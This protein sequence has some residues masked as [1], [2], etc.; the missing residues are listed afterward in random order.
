MDI[1]K[2]AVTGSAGSGKS[3]VCRGF[4][5]LGAAVLDCDV[6]ARQVVEPGS[7]GLT[8][9]T[10]V[11]GSTIIRKN[12]TL[13]RSSL[14][15][16]IINSRD[17]RKQL[18]DV[19]HP[20]ILEEMTAQMDSARQNGFKMVVVE[21]PLLFESGM[22]RFFDVTIA[23]AG[24]AGELVKRISKRDGVSM[25][26]AQKMLDLQ[27]PQQEKMQKADYVIKNIAGLAELFDLVA[28]LCKRI[29][30]EFLTT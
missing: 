23:V 21:V 24:S 8:K 12:G 18:E 10:A 19:L 28:N 4:G 20:L 25:G 7:P 13:D 17:K 22:D 16:L 2:I 3:H 1:L 27:M 29:E 15:T 30:K 11:F 9:V 14:R 6:I 5:K 26:E